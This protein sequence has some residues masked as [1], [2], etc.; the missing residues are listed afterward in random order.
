MA[1]RVILADDVDHFS[2][3]ITEA[4]G[5]HYID[6][7]G[8][9]RE[10]D[11]SDEHYRELVEAL[12]KFWNVARVCPA[13]GTA[14]AGNYSDGNPGRIRYW[15]DFRVWADQRGIKYRSDGGGFY[16]HRPDVREFD[17]WLLENG[18][19]PVEHNWKNHGGKRTGDSQEPEPA[20]RRKEHAA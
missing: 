5:T 12:A 6:L 13:P 1:T 20:D 18:R 4:D 11:V 3:I 16:P 15:K 10:I 2:G 19:I 8:I 17:R 7:D 14:M 9:W